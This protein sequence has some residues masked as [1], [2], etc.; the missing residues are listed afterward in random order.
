MI[1]IPD[2]PEL[3]LYDSE[4]YSHP[5]SIELD[6]DDGTSSCLIEESDYKSDFLLCPVKL[7]PTIMCLLLPF[8]HGVVG[9]VLAMCNVE[10]ILAKIKINIEF[11]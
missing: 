7:D 11:V 4:Y 9:I 2:S 5:P 1:M 3:F 8:G 6:N 10:R